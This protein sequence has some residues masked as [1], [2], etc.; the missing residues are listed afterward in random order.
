MVQNFKSL[1]EVQRRATKLVQGMRNV[2][3]EERLSRLGMTSVEERLQR[4]DLIMT[5]KML[6][7]KVKLDPEHFF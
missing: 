3:Y 5:Y 4:G 7:G 1:E 6:T 2:P